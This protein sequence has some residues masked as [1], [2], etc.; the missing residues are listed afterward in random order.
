MSHF[1]HDDILSPRKLNEPIDLPSPPDAAG[2]TSGDFASTGSGSMSGDGFMS[3]EGSE[4]PPENFGTDQGV[5]ATDN[6]A[7]GSIYIPV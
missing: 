6:T 4:Q 1:M 3:R 5:T 7:Y 2:V